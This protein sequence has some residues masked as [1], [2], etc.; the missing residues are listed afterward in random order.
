[1]FP[2]DFKK[3]KFTTTEAKLLNKLTEQWV[4]FPFITF[5]GF[6]PTELSFQINGRIVPSRFLLVSC[7]QGVLSLH[8]TGTVHHRLL[9]HNPVSPFP[10]G[11]LHSAPSFP[12]YY[13]PKLFPFCIFACLCVSL[14]SLS[15][16]SLGPREYM[17]F[18]VVNENKK[19]H[20]LPLLFVNTPE[21]TK[22]HTEF[23]TEV[24]NIHLPSFSLFW[25]VY[26]P[27][28]QQKVH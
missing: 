23:I 10:P 9:S 3:G 11:I 18:K 16:I 21:N 13:I 22:D 27:W 26:T 20:F 2:L 12:A 1:M 19:L 28:D 14:Y 5:S 6:S 24:L 8:T 4:L 7:H 15:V 17:I 25:W